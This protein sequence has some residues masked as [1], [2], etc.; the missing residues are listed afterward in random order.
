M[1][2][3]NGK[4][5]RQLLGFTNKTLFTKH[6]GAKD[7]VEPNWDI[8]NKRNCR[9]TEMLTKINDMQLTPAE[10]DIKNLID[11]TTESVKIAGILPLLNNQGRAIESVYFSWL[12]GYVAEIIFT[13]LIAKELGCS[14]LERNGG[15]DFTSK[16]T[17]KR[18]GDAD[19]IDETAKILIDVQ[20]G[21]TATNRCD[22][23]LH[24]VKQAK[25]KHGYNSYVFFIDLVEGSYGAI[26]L[27]QLDEAEFTPNPQWEGQL[28]HSVSKDD[29]KL[30]WKRLDKG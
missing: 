7:I 24:K 11:E 22:I 9:L 25:E 14:N 8:I 26:D 5:Y 13:P 20:C 18:T 2:N 23:K 12:L 30:L 10:L 19:L 16:E 29:F 27:G 6:L 21:I 15:D 28:T 17:F 3:T 4:E 1:K